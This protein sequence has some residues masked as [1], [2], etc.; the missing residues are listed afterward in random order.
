MV[1]HIKAAGR[2]AAAAQTYAS[3]VGG[4]GVLVAGSLP[5]LGPSYRYDLVPDD[6]TMA[7]VLST[8]A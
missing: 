2:A 3:A 1:E 8:R 7:A 5:P 6:A 4:K